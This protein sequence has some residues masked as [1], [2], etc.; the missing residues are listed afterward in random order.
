MICNEN[1]ACVTL[2]S[3][4]FILSPSPRLPL[5]I[6]VICNNILLYFVL[7]HSLIK[8]LLCHVFFLQTWT[9]VPSAT[10]VPPPPPAFPHHPSYVLKPRDQTESPHKYQ[11]SSSNQP[12]CGRMLGLRGMFRF[13]GK[14]YLLAS[15]QPLKA[16]VSLLKSGCLF[17]KPEFTYSV[18]Q[19][20]LGSIKEMV[21]NKVEKVASQ[22]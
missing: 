22:I 21:M 14:H 12:N 17:L 4:F 8:G 11:P 6:P 16:A 3:I 1:E 10:L 18:F 20:R 7:S 19:Q 2:S 15:N 5:F 13:A 9:C